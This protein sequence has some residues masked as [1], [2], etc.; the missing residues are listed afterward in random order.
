MPLTDTQLI[1]LSAASQRED[2]NVL[3]LPKS[4]KGGAATKVLSGLLGKGLIEEVEATLDKPRWRERD[5]APTM[6]LLTDAGLAA[7]DGDTPATGAR[8]G[9]G[10][11]TGGKA[12]KSRR[13]PRQVQPAAN[14]AREGGT[15]ADNKR[16]KLI[17]LLRRPEGA[18]IA[19]IVEAFGW[20]L[21]TVRG[22]IS[23]V[24][25]KKFGLAVTSEKTDG[26]GRV[27]IAD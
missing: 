4:L 19:E 27:Y 10:R 24:L 18:S 8:K 1:V 3:P 5:G 13:E 21:H 12:P 6:L 16:A 23:G 15:R 2:R 11:Q 20:Q 7:L 22:A 25:R 17:A 9:R 26:R 14:L